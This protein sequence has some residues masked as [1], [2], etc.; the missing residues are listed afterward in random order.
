MI[1]LETMGIRP[2]SAIIS[3]GAA[4][5]DHEQVLDTFYS[6]VNLNSSI[7]LGMTTDQSTI[8][9]WSKQ[10]VQARAAWQTEDAP[11]IEDA[12][13]QLNDWMLGH[14]S[15][16]EICPWGNGA[17]FDLVLMNH[18]FNLMGVDAPWKYYNHHC[19]RTMK[20]MFDVGQMPRSGTHHHALDD[21]VS[22][23]RHLH[24]ILQVHHLQLPV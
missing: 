3:I 13:K 17:D 4:L 23:V 8:D 19:F 18:A 12:L 21:A 9:W 22:Q 2:T 5:F 7:N 16:A 20:N 15:R 6:N 1:D 24:R 14:G 10:S 11:A